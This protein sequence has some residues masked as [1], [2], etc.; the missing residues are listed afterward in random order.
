MEG[1]IRHLEM[2][3]GAIRQSATDSL[4][5]KEF[6]ML[7]LIGI[8]ALLLR[9]GV[10]TDA[11]LFLFGFVLMFIVVFL[12]ILDFY[13]IHQSDLFKIL[14]NRVRV[15]P[16]DEIDFSMGIEKYSEELN[17]QYKKTLPFRLIASGFMH[18]GLF[19]LLFFGVFPPRLVMPN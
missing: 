10:R 18:A 15:R 17:E 14:Y 7:M 9:D 3:Q 4:R 2:I 5:I 19:A 16:E 6:A 11:I 12:F 1:K 13:F 8:V